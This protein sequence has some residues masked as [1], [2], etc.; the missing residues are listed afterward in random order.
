MKSKDPNPPEPVTPTAL[1]LAVDALALRQTTTE[2][3]VQELER[4]SMAL[5]FISLHAASDGEKWLHKSVGV[6]NP[7]M[8]NACQ[9]RWYCAI[10]G[11]GPLVAAL[12]LKLEKELRLVLRGFESTAASE[13]RGSAFWGAR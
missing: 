4:R 3:L 5:A 9:E 11:S 1:P 13:E 7:H 10:K 12:S 2:Q 6:P 8:P